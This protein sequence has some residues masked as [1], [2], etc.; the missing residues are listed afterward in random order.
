MIEMKLISDS[1]VFAP[2][3]LALCAFEES[4]F[5]FVASSGLYEPVLCFLVLALRTLIVCYG[6]RTFVF[7][8]DGYFFC[9]FL[10]GFL[11]FHVFS[12]FFRVATRAEHDA[13]VLVFFRS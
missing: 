7:G 5:W 4:C 12:V 10:D 8:D 9:V 13:L 6:E 11:D 1:L 3:V 2:R